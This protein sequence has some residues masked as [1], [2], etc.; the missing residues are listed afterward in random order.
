M[1]ELS[2]VVNENNPRLYAAS[3][4]VTNITGV[5]NSVDLAFSAGGDTGHAA[6]FALS[7]VT[8]TSTPTF[9]AQPAGVTQYAGT[10]VTLAGGV[11]SALP[12]TYKWQR[13]APGATAFV[14]VADGGN[15]S[16]AGTPTLSITGIGDPNVGDY[17]LLAQNSNGSTFSSTVKIALIPTAFDVT[18]PGDP[19]V[20][21]SN[22]SPGSEG[23]A[24]SIDNQPTK[25][26]NFDILNTGFTVT[27]A[28]GAT[29]INAIAL[30]SANDAPERDPSSFTIEGSNDGTT[31]SLI[32]SNSVP[33][34]SD[35][36]TKQTF[37]FDNH[38][39]FKIYRVIFP[40]V[41]NAPSAAN[42]M[43]I[44]EVELLGVTVPPDVTQP[45]D[46]I[47]ASSNNSPGSEGVANAIDN[48]PTKYL[49]FDISNTGFTVTPQIGA[50]IVTGI[51]LTSANDAPERDPANF[52]LEG[53]NDGTNYTLIV[54]NTVPAFSDRYV[55]QDFTFPNTKPFKTYRILFPNVVNAPEC[56]EQH[57]DIGGAVFRGGRS[58]G[59]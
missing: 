29:L 25:Y 31:F 40:T 58:A 5:I 39:A 32:V 41:V 53:S 34:F 4:A 38:T 7:G 6:V 48:Q 54:S 15:I 1:T 36:Y 12:V 2:N 57:A 23:V 22:N 3:I 16:G 56:G 28:V 13:K 11:A 24:N 9:T 35:R 27:P 46:T 43:Q 51:G 55:E 30:T 8:A 14:N 18:Q 37:P 33:L 50:T 47:V 21:S 10:D 42:S 19:I 44:S 26:L 52:T 17:R 49:N 45:G 59:L 20:A